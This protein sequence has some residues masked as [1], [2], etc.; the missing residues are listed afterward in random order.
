MEIIKCQVPDNFTICDMSDFH[1]G[2]PNCAEETLQEVVAKIKDTKDCYVIFKGDAIE[3][4]LPND[5]RYLH[6]AVREGL[7]SPKE[8]ADRVVELFN[9][10]RSRILA[11]GIGNHEL[12]LWNTMDFGKYISDQLGASYG[13]YNFKIHFN[14][15]GNELMFKTYHTHGM[16]G[17]HSNAKDEIQYEANR[18]AG[19]KH[20]LVKSGHA[21]CIYMSRGHDH[22]LVVVDPTVQN[23]LYL[24]DDGC[25]IHQQYHLPS[26]QNAGFIPPDSRWYATT[27]SFRKLY[28]KP[29][30]GTIDYGEV[31]GYSPAELGYALV[32]VNDRQIISVSKVVAE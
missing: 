13:A 19:L 6:S 28:S 31:I 25:G 14:S 11:W 30:L 17:M 12:K 20:K 23:K 29:G 27:G 32:E 21:D 1:L 24:T 15:F 2:S 10:I 22:Q 26:I 7:Q 18:K 8:Q 3:A 5:K 4:I 9:P 16:G